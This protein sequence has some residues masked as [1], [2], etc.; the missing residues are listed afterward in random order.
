MIC[1]ITLY[2]SVANP[3]LLGQN[4]M[5]WF[6]RRKAD[7]YTPNQSI[8]VTMGDLSAG[9]KHSRLLREAVL[10]PKENASR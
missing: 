5:S 10:W 4:H 1:R 9:P 7:A 3:G 6:S 8:F 2:V